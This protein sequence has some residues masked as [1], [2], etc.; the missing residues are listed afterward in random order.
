MAISVKN[1]VSKTKI[2]IGMLMMLGISLITTTLLPFPFSTL[3]SLIISIFVVAKYWSKSKRT[4]TLLLLAIFGINFAVALIIPFPFSLLPIFAIG[5]F[6]IDVW[7]N[8][9]KKE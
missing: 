1:T 5:Y 7:L 8:R 4:I 6:V 2:I 3:L 9:Q